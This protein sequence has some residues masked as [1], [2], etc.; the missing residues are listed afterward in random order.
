MSL[1]EQFKD[2]RDTWILSRRCQ[3]V[4]T[5]KFGKF[6]KTI[7]YGGNKL[8]ELLVKSG[9]NNTMEAF[10]SPV[11]KSNTENIHLDA[12]TALKMDRNHMNTMEDND[13]ANDFNY[14]ESTSIVYLNGVKRLLWSM[15]I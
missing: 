15:M 9:T 7:I 4:L 10:Y 5:W 3:S 1:A 13:V 11:H 6:S 2:D 12:N 14:T 8:P